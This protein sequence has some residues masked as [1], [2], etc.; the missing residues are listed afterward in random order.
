MKA[1]FIKTSRPRYYVI[2][3]PGLV[4][5]M[6]ERT[7]KMNGDSFGHGNALRPTGRMDQIVSLQNQLRFLFLCWL[8]VVAATAATAVIVLAIW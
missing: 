5:K 3:S 7:R 2:L 6:S 8:G 4:L 1:Y